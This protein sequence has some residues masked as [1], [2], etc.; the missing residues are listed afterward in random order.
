MLLGKNKIFQ[1]PILAMDLTLDG[2]EASNQS[3]KSLFLRNWI[4]F[5]NAFAY[6]SIVLLSF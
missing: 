3:K 6:L 1:T 5:V 4:S 2:R